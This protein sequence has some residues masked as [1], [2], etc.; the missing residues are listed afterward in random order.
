MR[1]FVVYLRCILL[2]VACRMTIRLV[3]SQRNI[4][5]AE[6][7]NSKNIR[8]ILIHQVEIQENFIGNSFRLSATQVG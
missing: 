2:S 1:D 8:M 7:N 3:S 6:L 4:N 5:Y